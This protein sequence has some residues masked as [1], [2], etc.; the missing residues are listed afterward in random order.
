MYWSGFENGFNATNVFSTLAFVWLIAHPLSNILKSWSQIGELLACFGRIQ[1]YLYLDEREDTRK[2]VAESLEDKSAK[3]EADQLPHDLEQ[4]PL[5]LTDASILSPK[6]KPLFT[7]N[8]QFARSTVTMVIGR[9][10][11]GK[12]VLLKALL[13]EAKIASGSILARHQ[14]IGYCDQ[15]VWLRNVSIRDNIIGESPYDEDW[16]NRVVSSCLL[17]DLDQLPKGHLSAVGS[18]GSNLSG[19]Q[20]QRVV[21][22]PLTWRRKFRPTN[23]PRRWRGLFILTLQPFFWM[24]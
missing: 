17:G 24:M 9:T 11:S 4:Y 7:A 3:P 23:C 8:V 15:E 13:G 22:H 10:G 19:G 12:S 1:A 16:Y 2:Y 18:R 6:D 20:K 21:S 5:Q 14:Q